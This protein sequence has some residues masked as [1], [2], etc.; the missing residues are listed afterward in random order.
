MCDIEQAVERIEVYLK[1]LNDRFTDATTIDTQYVP[2]TKE[3]HSLLVADLRVLLDLVDDAYPTPSP[4]Y[5]HWLKAT[6]PTT[7]AS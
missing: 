5:S 7:P 1:A 2:S 4:M 3:S 6:T